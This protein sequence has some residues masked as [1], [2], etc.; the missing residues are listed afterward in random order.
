MDF[1][2]WTNA[3]SVANKLIDDQHKSM[4]MI[5]NQIHRAVDAVDKKKIVKLCSE[6]EL[7]VKMHFET[8]E[9]LMKEN[10]FQGYISHKLEHDRYYSKV[11]KLSY[12]A[13]EDHSVVNMT[14]LDSFKTWFYN[15]LDLNDRKL[16]EFL[17]ERGIK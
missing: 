1:L 5:I 15:H 12:E 9:E 13:A 7:N 11:L 17:K 10:N 8:E 2:K 14:F 3:E 6:L 16:G 4:I